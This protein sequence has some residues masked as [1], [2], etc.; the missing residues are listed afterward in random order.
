MSNQGEFKTDISDILHRYLS[1][2]QLNSKEAAMLEK[3]QAASSFN[4]QLLEE[5]SDEETVKQALREVYQYDKAR[6][7]E[8]LGSRIIPAARPVHKLRKWLYAAAAAVLLATTTLLWYQYNNPAKR[9]L[10]VKQAEILPAGNKATLTLANGQIVVLDSA[11][12]QTLTQGSTT[13]RQDKGALR[14]AGSNANLAAVWNTLNT[15]RGGQFQLT[16]PDGSRVW[17][18]AATTLRFP[19]AFSDSSRIVELKGEAYFEIATVVKNGVK[20]P[21]KVMTG[22]MSVAVVGTH[23]NIMAYQEEGHITTTLLEGAVR[24]VNNAGNTLIAPGQQGTLEEGATSFK[25]QKANLEETM[26]WKNGY[27]WFNNASLQTIMRQLSRWYDVDIQYEGPIPA[28]Q[29]GG[30]INRDLPLSAVL[31]Y[32]AENGIKTRIS[33]RTITVTQ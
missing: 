16:L 14:Y 8:K 25:V 9:G 2:E 32:L 20:V 12:H 15:P 22:D 3:W 4:R 26:S 28:V 27:F 19:V 18:N 6:L 30:I 11:G 24:L 7:W 5:M 13:I 23:F 10:A 1:G 17:L 21:F 31:E 33:G 29:F